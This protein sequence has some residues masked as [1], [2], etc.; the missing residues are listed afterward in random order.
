MTPLLLA[1]LLA[2]LLSLE[3]PVSILA[4]TTGGVQWKILLYIYMH[5][6]TAETSPTKRGQ[7]MGTSGLVSL[8]VARM[9]S[10]ACIIDLDSTVSTAC[11]V[12]TVQGLYNELCHYKIQ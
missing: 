2:A 10:S 12:I 3:L 1:S 6:N 7:L 4:A 8:N 11:E 5:S 9:S